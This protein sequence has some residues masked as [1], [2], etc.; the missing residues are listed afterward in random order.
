MNR[1]K[2][3]YSEVDECDS[4]RLVMTLYTVG[5]KRK[6][7]DAYGLWDGNAPLI[8]FL[9]L[10]LY[11]LFVCLLNLLL[12]YFLPSVYFLPYL[13]KKSNTNLLFQLNNFYLP[14]KLRLTHLV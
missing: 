13:F 9:T 8:H 5:V 2:A 6:P 3:E 12:S 7:L 4:N 14:I 1:D 10:V 11:K